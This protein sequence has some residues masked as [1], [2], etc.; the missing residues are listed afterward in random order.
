MLSPP[1]SLH[2]VQQA[3]Q[4]HDALYSRSMDAAIQGDRD[5]SDRLARIANRALA[6]YSRRFHAYRR[7]VNQ[8][9]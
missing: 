5:L 9:A 2:L 1:V 3:L 6:R 8:G 7:T 4:L